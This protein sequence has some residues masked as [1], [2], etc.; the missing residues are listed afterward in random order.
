MAGN[1]QNQ[2]AN[3]NINKI[4]KPLAKLTKRQRD[5]IKNKK[6]RNK[7]GDITTDTKKKQ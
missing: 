5:I 3:E 6:I 7:I 1:N 2:K 4:D